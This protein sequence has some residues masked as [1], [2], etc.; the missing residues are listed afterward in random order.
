MWK[1]L[2]LLAVSLEECS[3]NTRIVVNNFYKHEVNVKI[4]GEGVGGCDVVLNSSATDPSDC[5]YSTDTVSVDY[6]INKIPRNEFVSCWS[7]RAAYRSYAFVLIG[8]CGAPLI[9]NSTR[10]YLPIATSTEPKH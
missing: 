1:E 8:A 2:L 3:G 4:K 9:T 7:S 6:F 5:W 10:S